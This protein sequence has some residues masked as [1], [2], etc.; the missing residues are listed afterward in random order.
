V[1]EDYQSD[2]SIKVE[3]EEGSLYYYYYYF[4]RS[5]EEEELELKYSIRSK[6]EG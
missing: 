6:E 5:K 3:E 2:C 1:V 4:I